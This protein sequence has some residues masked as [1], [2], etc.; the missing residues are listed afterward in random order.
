MSRIV[1]IV[2]LCASCALADN[3]QQPRTWTS[4]GGNYYTDNRTYTA[5]GGYWLATWGAA[6][7]V[8]ALD[9]TPA[10]SYVNMNNAAILATS[11]VGTVS[12]WVLSWN[13]QAGNQWFFTTSKGN[14]TGY[15]LFSLNAATQMQFIVRNDAGADICNVVAG[16]SI[17]PTGVW[18]HVVFEQT[19]SGDTASMKMWYDAQPQPL[20]WA[21]DATKSAWFHSLTSTYKTIGAV[22]MYDGINPHVDRFPGRVDELCVWS[23]LLSGSEVTNLYNSGVGIKG[24]IAQSPWNNGLICGYH[25]DEGTGTNCLDYSGNGYTATTKNSPTWVPGKVP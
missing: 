10:N 24:D 8:Y 18:H 11:T 19:G 15:L 17:G 5:A 12:A 13:N 20:R 16:G 21:V 7:N 1:A 4:A 14:S 2:L 23:R 22:L 6:A 3:V 25:Y 9:F